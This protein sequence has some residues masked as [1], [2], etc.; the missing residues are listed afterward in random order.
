[1]LEKKKDENFSVDAKKEKSIEKF[2]PENFGFK[3]ANEYDDCDVYNR[4]E[5]INGKERTLML[6]ITLTLNYYKKPKSWIILVDGKNFKDLLPE[7]L[8]PNHFTVFMGHIE[9]DNDFKFI[10]DRLATHPKEIMQMSNISG[11]KDED[12]EEIY[13]PLN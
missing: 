5:V 12:G 11:G 3:I 6:D 8:I 9:T 2:N 13:I 10:L 1:M 4:L 7:E